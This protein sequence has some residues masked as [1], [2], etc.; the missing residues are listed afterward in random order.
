MEVAGRTAFVTGGAGGIGLA[1]A[2]KLLD[3]GA[4]V[5]IADIRKDRLDA[6]LAELG[7][8]GAIGIRL[9][10]ADRVGFAAAADAAE[11]ALGPVTILCNNAGVN[12]FA[13]I[14]ECSYDDWDWLLGVNL[15]GV[16][17]GC[18]TFVPRMKARGEGGHIV[19]TA[20]MAS[21][22]AEPAAGIYTTTKFAVRGLSE[23]LR[24]SLA[25]YD[26][27]VS[28]LCPGLVRSAIYQSGMTRPGARPRRADD[29]DAE[30]LEHLAELHAGGMEPDEV[31]A[32]VI[33][34]I[35]ANS[36]YIFP[37][38]EFRD[39]LREAFDDIL[40]ALPEPGPADLDRLAA[41]EQRRRLYAA[42]RRAAG[43]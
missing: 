27:G 3:A 1:V 42:A 5:A 23:S 26:I 30:F 20:S 25:P 21:F 38:P 9:D 6:A 29:D 7:R 37:H 4:K 35:R 12:L 10:V 41:E 39:E 32:R 18:Q 31:A 14:D 36:R 28:C 40:D 16:I 19:N 43:H 33:D 15:H 13:A 17:N 22:L 34:G 11:A 2:R 8:T 24:W